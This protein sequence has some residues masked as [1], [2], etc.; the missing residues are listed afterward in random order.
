MKVLLCDAY[1]G[2][3]IHVLISVNIDSPFEYRSYSIFNESLIK[4]IKV[5]D[6]GRQ[7][8]VKCDIQLWKSVNHGLLLSNPGPSSTKPT[9]PTQYGHRGHPCGI[10]TYQRKRRGHSQSFAFCLK[11][12]Q[13][14]TIF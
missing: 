2:I 1:M 3:I 10:I 12:L 9:K 6:S 4:I 13:K 11:A 5:S 7:E 14:L 8:S